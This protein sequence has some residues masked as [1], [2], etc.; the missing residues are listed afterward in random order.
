MLNTEA[1]KRMIPDFFEN[2]NSKEE[3]EAKKMR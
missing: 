3:W 2:I 1:K